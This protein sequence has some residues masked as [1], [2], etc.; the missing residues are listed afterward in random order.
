MAHVLRIW[1]PY[2]ADKGE[3]S[4]T[5]PGHHGVGGDW[6]S[7]MATEHYFN[8]EEDTIKIECQLKY[9]G[10]Q[11]IEFNTDESTVWITLNTDQ[12]KQLKKELSKLK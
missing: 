4:L 11:R 3:S 2:M 6:E 10:F 5:T 12:L 1:R 8:Y 7:N 9:T